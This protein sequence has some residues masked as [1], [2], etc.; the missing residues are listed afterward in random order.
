MQ[1]TYS[2]LRSKT[3]WL[4]VV[5]ALLPIANAI[6]PTLPMGVQNIVEIILSV[7]AMITHN[8]TAQNSNAVN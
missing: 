2:L 6:A 5:T 4:L 8:M 7:L 1:N 3:F